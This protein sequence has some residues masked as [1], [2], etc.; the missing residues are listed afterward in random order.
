MTTSPIQ[1]R[2]IDHVTLVVK[3]LDASRRFYVDLIGM[4][5][6]ERPA[7]NFPGLWFKIA[8]TLIHLIGEHDESGPGGYPDQIHRTSTRNHHLAF[9]VDDAAVVAEA[10]KVHG[11][12]LVSDVKRRP[13]G[14]AQVFAHDPDG[15]VIEFCSV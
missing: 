8:T 2:S 1:V 9:A 15:H 14:A 7:F 12:P 4:E 3:D 10:L 11:V 13:D 5:E 6:V